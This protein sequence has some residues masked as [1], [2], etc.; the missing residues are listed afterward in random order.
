MP[1]LAHFMGTKPD[2]KVQIRDR[3][4]DVSDTR[5]IDKDLL[6]SRTIENQPVG[7]F[8]FL[9]FH[10]PRDNKIVLSDTAMLEMNGIDAGLTLSRIDSG[11]NKQ[12]NLYFSSGYQ[13]CKNL[14]LSPVI[15]YGHSD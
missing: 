4:L 1:K 10:D 14:T 2:W 15:E 6:K 7:L 5:I 13:G 11:W 3:I 8:S 9:I 12:P